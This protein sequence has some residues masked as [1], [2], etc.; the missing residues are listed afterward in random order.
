MLATFNSENHTKL[1]V[2]D[3]MKIDGKF[4]R[5]T[6]AIEKLCGE[7]QVEGTKFPE[8]GAETWT[9]NLGDVSDQK[10]PSQTGALDRV[11]PANK[12]NEKSSFSF[13]FECFFHRFSSCFN[14]FG[15]EN[16]KR[17]LRI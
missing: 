8:E 15:V 3:K 10:K 16:F 13:S 5:K 17:Q 7:S 11:P 12:K 1:F 4:E 6:I 2:A 14:Q 9:I